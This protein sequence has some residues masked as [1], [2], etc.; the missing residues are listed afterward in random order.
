MPD[1]IIEI[2]EVVEEKPKIIEKQAKEVVEEK[3]EITFSQAKV[4]KITQLGNMTVTLSDKLNSEVD[5]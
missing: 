1:F 3:V 4:S 5:L 2:E